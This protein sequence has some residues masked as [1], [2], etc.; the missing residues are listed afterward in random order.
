VE[1]YRNMRI[2]TNKSVDLHNLGRIDRSQSTL[3]YSQGGSY[4]NIG[5]INPSIYLGEDKIVDKMRKVA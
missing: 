2:A 5:E 3:E 4:T 1:K